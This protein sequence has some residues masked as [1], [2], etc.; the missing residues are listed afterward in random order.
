MVKIMNEQELL[1]KFKKMRKENEG[2]IEWKKN[3]YEEIDKMDN[4]LLKNT[5]HRYRLKVKKSSKEKSQSKL[6]TFA[7]NLF[8]TVIPII[9]VM[10]SAF[11]GGISGLIS[12]ATEM[13]GYINPSKEV[14][15]IALDIERELTV[16]VMTAILILAVSILL[17]YT[18]SWLIEELRTKR[19]I[20]EEIYDEEMLRILKKKIKESV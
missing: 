14:L 2:Y 6:S 19:R 12:I 20:E 10:I 17:C 4:L 7:M 8:A 5:Y 9:V 3:V 16:S 13:A 11:T 1:K 18:I 15:Q